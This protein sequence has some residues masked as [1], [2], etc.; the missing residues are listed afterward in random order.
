M[1]IQARQRPHFIKLKVIKSTIRYCANTFL[2][3]SFSVGTFMHTSAA[4]ILISF[5][6]GTLLSRTLDTSFSISLEGLLYFR[7]LSTDRCPVRDIISCSGMPAWYKEVRFPEWFVKKIHLQW[8]SVKCISRRNA[9]QVFLIHFRQWRILK[10]MLNILWTKMTLIQSTCI[11]LV[12][13][14]S[15]LYEHPILVTEGW[16]WP[17]LSCRFSSTALNPKKLAVIEKVFNKDFAVISEY[18]FLPQ[19]TFRFTRNRLPLQLPQRLD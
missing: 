5:E 7:T 6:F 9:S 4:S 12:S 17:T 13:P 8:P 15:K 10:V 19:L 11:R 1:Y 18:S 16:I 14:I 3:P 2:S